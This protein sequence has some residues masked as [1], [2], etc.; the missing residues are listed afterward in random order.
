[1]TRSGSIIT[2]QLF[3]IFMSGDDTSERQVESTDQLG[4]NEKYC[5]SCSDIISTQAEVC[6]SCGAPQDGKSSTNQRQSQQSRQRSQA[7][8]SNSERRFKQEIDDKKVEGW[9]VKNRQG[10]RVVLIKRRYGSLTAHIVLFI[11]TFYTVGLANAAYLAYKYF[12]DPDKMV[13]RKSEFE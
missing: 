13:I 6:P 3:L 10:D 8:A 1:M 11:F 4:P 12:G 5:I 9:D 7:S 2:R